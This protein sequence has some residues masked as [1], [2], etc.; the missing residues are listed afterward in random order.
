M[1]GTEAQTVKNRRPAVGKEKPMKNTEAQTV[2]N[3]RPAVGKE[4]P[5]K[6]TKAKLLKTAARLFASRGTEGVSTRELAGQAGV[7]LCAISYYFGSKQ[8][9][10]EAVI[11]EVIDTVRQNLLPA[12]GN[13][14][15]AADN[16]RE[17]VKTVIGR[18]FDFL[19]GD[20]ISDVQARLMINEIIS[21]SSVYDKIYQNI[22]EPAHRQI[23]RLAAQET[24]ADENSPQVLILTHTLFG[25]AV[26]FRIH[27]E[28][29]LRRM[30]IKQYTP[31][32]LNEIK[33]HIEENCDA[34]LEQA[35]RQK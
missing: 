31:E 22:L 29:L 19:C 11:D 8:K 2:K 10:Y 35:R 6:N 23:S 4:K 32:L 21:P 25:Q 27:K 28:A 12:P 13:G 3:R 24:G 9:L 34:I 18:F 30:K 16:P 33:K 20:K 17:S 1:K 7:N 26:M 14:A 5:M 15:P